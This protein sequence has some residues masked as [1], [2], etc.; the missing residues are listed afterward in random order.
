MTA[1]EILNLKDRRDFLDINYDPVKKET[2]LGK[3]MPEGKE[4]EIDPEEF[5]VVSINNFYRFK[6][7]HY[8][9][10]WKI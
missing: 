4:K 7:D 3:I 6:V 9:G 1:S 8:L 5:K 10:T 2:I